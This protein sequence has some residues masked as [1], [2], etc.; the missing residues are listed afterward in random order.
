MKHRVIT[1][2]SLFILL[3]CA[4]TAGYAQQHFFS[5]APESTFKNPAQKRVIIPSRFRTLVLD[6]AALLQF[7]QKVPA[8]GNT[9][10]N[11]KKAVVEIP[12]PKG[13][14]ATFYIW[15]SAVMAPELAAKF[16]GIKSY[17][18]RESP[19]LQQLSKSTGRHLDFMQ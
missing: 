4:G 9:S 17:T 12:M 14:T 10:K 3:M 1:K 11:H 7:L 16:P 2:Y 19:M 15:E 6:T 13:D 18:G 8:T 5:D